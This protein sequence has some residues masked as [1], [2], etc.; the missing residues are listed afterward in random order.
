[1]VNSRKVVALFLV[2]VFICGVILS[3]SSSQA[4]PRASNSSLPSTAA[5]ASDYAHL[6]KVTRSISIG[7][8]L[9]TNVYDTY[10][11]RNDG[12]SALTSFEIFTDS[13]YDSKLVYLGQLEGVGKP[14]P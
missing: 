12:R 5:T 13:G 9:L 3:L 14:F 1:M 8:Y 6:T 10:T 7:Q 4:Q 11:I 2:S